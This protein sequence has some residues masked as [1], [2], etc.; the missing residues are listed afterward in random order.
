MFAVI[1]VGCPAL[2]TGGRSGGLLVGTD[3]V[4]FTLFFGVYCEA[5]PVDTRTPPRM[6]LEGVWS[7]CALLALRGSADD[8]S[9]GPLK[10]GLE[11]RD[12]GCD[13]DE[14]AFDAVRGFKVSWFCSSEHRVTGLLT[15][16]STRG[17]RGRLVE[18]VRLHRLAGVLGHSETYSLRLG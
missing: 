7:L 15:T 17:H 13:N 18:P 2:A 4:L 12:A 5:V 9:L 8:A 6:E 1:G 14:V 11:K 10:E 3:D 16:S